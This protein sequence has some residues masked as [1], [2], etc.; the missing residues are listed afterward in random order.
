MLSEQQIRDEIARRDRITL[1]FIIVSFLL[2]IPAVVFMFWVDKANP[3]AY[4][5]SLFA[6][7]LLA[8]SFISLAVG[9]LRADRIKLRCPRC[10]AVLS[11]WLRHV[12]RT[13]HCEGCHELIVG[14]IPPDDAVPVEA[15]L[16]SRKIR[17]LRHLRHRT[18]VASSLCE[19]VLLLTVFVGLLGAVEYEFPWRWISLAAS[20]IS[21]GTIWYFVVKQLRRASEIPTLCPNCHAVLSGWAINEGE[22]VVL[23]TSRCPVCNCVILRKDPWDEALL[24]RYK[25]YSRAISNRRVQRQM[26]RSLWGL[27]AYQGILVSASYAFHHSELSPSS[28]FHLLISLSG[29]AMIA[30]AVYGWRRS[31]NNRCIYPL[32]V[33]CVLVAYTLSL[34]WLEFSAPLSHD[35]LKAFFS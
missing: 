23:K 17:E 24:E 8:S 32:I 33:L 28:R 6:G 29:L 14:E 26:H 5:G 4:R 34:A 21:V 30:I 13:H 18:S 3:A 1:P 31:C 11:F 9:H 27:V 16:T 2:M 35:W 12:L 22:S 7:S 25:R 10:Q 20:L 15:R 19:S